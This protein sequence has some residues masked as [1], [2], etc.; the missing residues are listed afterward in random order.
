MTLPEMWHE[1]RHAEQTQGAL[2]ARDRDAYVGS[3]WVRMHQRLYMG[4]AP[5]TFMLVGIPLGI[6]SHRV[7]PR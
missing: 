1:V 4:V 6:R 2:L 5:L 7:N 3:L